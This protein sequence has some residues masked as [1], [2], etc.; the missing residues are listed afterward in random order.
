M[1]IASCSKVLVLRLLQMHLG[2]T[3]SV[4][5]CEMPAFLDRQL[6]W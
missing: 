2:A 1:P 3:P 6:M 4:A 5:G